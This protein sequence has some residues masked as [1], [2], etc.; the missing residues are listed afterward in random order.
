MSEYLLYI[1]ITHRYIIYPFHLQ[2][3]QPSD[4]IIRQ[5]K[6][7]TSN[8]TTTADSERAGKSF[9]YIC[10]QRLVSWSPYFDLGGSSVNTANQQVQ[11]I[12]HAR[13]LPHDKNINIC[14]QF[15]Y[16]DFT[17]D[18]PKKSFG[19]FQKPDNVRKLFKRKIY[20]SNHCE[21]RSDSYW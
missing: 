17:R 19:L 7:A 9:R 1:G 11:I 16:W 13:H 18:L 6:R 20:I 2:G 15:I 5:I 14:I 10:T 8:K 12:L 4:V 3:R 21:T